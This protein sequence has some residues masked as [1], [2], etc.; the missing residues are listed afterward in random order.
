[1][2][3]SSFPNWIV[4]EVLPLQ[5]RNPTWHRLDGRSSGGNRNVVGRFE[6]LGQVW[7]V[8][9]DTRFDPILRAYS[10]I[11]NGSKSPFIIKAA[12]VRACLDWAPNFAIEGKPKYFY[13]YGLAGRSCT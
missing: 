3:Y 5:Q 7:V 10:V 2:I 4:A 1:M 13:F 6:H 11:Q 12:K 8:H 9:G